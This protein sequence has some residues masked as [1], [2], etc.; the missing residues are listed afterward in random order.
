MM[1]FVERQGLRLYRTVS[2]YRL[3]PDGRGLLNFLVGAAAA[4]YNVG[5]MTT[6]GRHRASSRRCSSIMHQL[7]RLTRRHQQQR[8]VL[9]GG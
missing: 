4:R 5:S 9:P 8:A 3:L 2:I 6:F 7:Q 1:I